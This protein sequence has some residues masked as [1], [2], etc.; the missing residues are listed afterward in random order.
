MSFAGR[1][2][3]DVESILAE[4][5][6]ENTDDKPDNDEEDNDDTTAPGDGKPVAGAKPVDNKVL[7]S[8]DFEYII[9]DDGTIEIV[10]YA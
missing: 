10:G 1:D 8:D 5:V 4:A 3:T 6:K 7:E 2:K 9:Y